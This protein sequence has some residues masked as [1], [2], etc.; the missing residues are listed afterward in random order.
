ML[1]LDTDHLTE[2]QKG[3]SAEAKRLK[4]RLD[5]ATEPYATTII[6]ME[7]IM[8]GWMA[9]LRRVH[10]PRRQINAYEKLQQLFRFCATW[11]LLEWNAAAADEFDALKQAKI[12]VGTMDL[13]IA[14]ICL[15][16][17]AT[18]LTRNIKHFSAVPDL[19]VEDWLQ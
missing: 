12:R 1:V 10:E 13:K 19:Q 16:N 14:S 5:V 15:A 6:S 18:L 17:D 8:R 9:A 7:E 2:Y 4:Q 11:N 3:T